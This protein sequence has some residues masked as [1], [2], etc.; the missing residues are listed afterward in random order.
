MVFECNKCL[1][2]FNRKYNLERHLSKCKKK[3]D[4]QCILCG[5][6]CINTKDLVNHLRL[7]KTI[8]KVFCDTFA[9]I[10][11]NNRL[12]CPLCHSDLK[13]KVSLKKHL[14]NSCKKREIQ[15]YD[16]DIVKKNIENKNKT[17]TINN[18]II[19]NGTINNSSMNIDN[20]T[21]IKILCYTKPNLSHIKDIIHD[22]MKNGI[23]G[24]EELFK[25]IYFNR[26]HP[27]NRSIK[28]FNKR[29]NIV[30]LNTY[31]MDDDNNQV[32]IYKQIKELSLFIR[33][34]NSDIYNIYYPRFKKK[35]KKL[36]GI[37]KK[38]DNH[39]DKLVDMENKLFTKEFNSMIRDVISYYDKHPY[40]PNEEQNSS[41]NLDQLIE[42]EQKQLDLCSDS[43]SE[44]DNNSD[45][46]SDHDRDVHLGRAHGHVRPLQCDSES[47]EEYPS[48]MTKKKS[49]FQMNLKSDIIKS[50]KN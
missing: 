12:K 14:I 50:M 21:N 30:K 35:N 16:K 3:T 4:Y 49:K 42:E 31:D 27:E 37:M 38:V 29:H 7:C 24:D 48:V 9:Y 45:S 26:N 36:S 22:C 10:M 32:S 47:E 19:N 28:L 18:G 15:K 1:K 46:E 41:L 20:S 6:F 25:Q 11:P 44:I 13:D 40:Q 39:L 33:N 43:N 17:K 5:D 2:I 23:K 34:M 8:K